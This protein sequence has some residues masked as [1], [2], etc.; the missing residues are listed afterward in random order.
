M[1]TSI[2]ERSFKLTTDNP[3]AEILLVDGNF[4]VIA[5][6][7][8]PLTHSAPPG[9]YAMKVKVGDQES[10][11]L[12]TV[13]P[14]A[15]PFERSLP[16]PQ[17]ESPIP[18]A[19]TSTT[20]EYHQ[21]VAS[22]L[23][24]PG[25]ATVS[26]GKGSAVTVCVRDPSKTNFAALNSGTSEAE[27][28][29]YAASF[30]GFCI[31][32]SSGTCIVDLDEKAERNMA[33]G[34]LAI[35]VEL[36]PGW[37]ALAYRSTAGWICSPLPT[38]SEWALQVY[39]NVVPSGQGRFALIPDLPGMAV[40]FGRLGSGFAP[41]RDDWL[42]GETVR[43][44][45]LEGRNYVDTPSM[46][47][48]L[49]GKFDD[50][51]LG[52][53]GAHLLL[54]EPKPELAL[55]Q[56]IVENLE[57]LLGASHPDV[58]ALAVACEQAAGT[59][60]QPGHADILASRI[61]ALAGPPLLA[62]GWDVLLAMAKRHNALLNSAPALFKV[63][64]DLMPNGVFVAW[65]Q[66]VLGAETMA[67]AALPAPVRVEV[68]PGE[69]VA[70]SLPP[71][72]L[73]T[74]TPV[75]KSIGATG[76]IAAI[77]VLAGPL[78]AAGTKI[79]KQIRRKRTKPEEPNLAAQIAEVDS[80]EKA[81]NALAELARRYDWRRL[82]PELRKNSEWMSHLSGLQRDLLMLLRDASSDPVSIEG[83]N[84]SFVEQLLQTY[85]VPLSTLVE[86]LSDMEL[87]GW[88]GTTARELAK[89]AARKQPKLDRPS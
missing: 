25:A 31:L 89:A 48:M 81:A 85:R 87:G 45:L 11:E 23:L 22:R 12:L 3:Q 62:R 80:N 64:R 4:R 82:L 15:M 7:P 26:L 84:A 9:L 44:G 74:R 72:V 88:V 61:S 65:C 35:A 39:I 59:A 43:Q 60:E 16:A 83:L 41:W 14:N 37:Y 32:D 73:A 18:L 30:S 6:G 1:P 10:E 38:V 8:T 58:V 56:E 77:G 78:I 68:A 19:H 55:V 79:L 70:A 21:S 5:R 20:H 29:A 17:F 86:A 53:Y 24:A 47:Q 42:A 75:S 63:A 49:S 67:K 33:D 71:D 34:Y 57:G 50:P 40:V 13:E 52:L 27:R 76:V 28:A 36:D 69:L 2:S 46:R 51:M 54:V 66:R